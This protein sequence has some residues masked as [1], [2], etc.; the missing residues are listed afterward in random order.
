MSIV[1]K[2]KKNKWLCTLAAVKLHSACN[3]MA[4]T[5]LGHHMHCLNSRLNNA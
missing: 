4:T 3:K 2:R 1:C 5:Y